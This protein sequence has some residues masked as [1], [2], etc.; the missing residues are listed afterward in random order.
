MFSYVLTSL[1]LI[2]E[3]K[4]IENDRTN[5]VKPT[6][7]EKED[8]LSQLEFSNNNNKELLLAISNQENAINEGII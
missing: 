2:E 5:L 6:T 8:L 3:Y 7:K 1:V 4:R